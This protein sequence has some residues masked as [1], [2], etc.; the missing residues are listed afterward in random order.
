[1]IFMNKHREIR[2]TERADRTG[3]SGRIFRFINEHAASGGGGLAGVKQPKKLETL[4]N[5]RT[6]PLPLLFLSS[7]FSFRFIVRLRR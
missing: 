3:R 6:R 1:M 5:L 2:P 7:S 4:T